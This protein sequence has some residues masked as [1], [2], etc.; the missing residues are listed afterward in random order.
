MASAASA[1][2]VGD[3]DSDGS[4]T[5]RRSDAPSEAS[6]VLVLKRLDGPDP[7]GELRPATASGFSRLIL[8]FDGVFGAAVLLDTRA[9]G[10]LF[11]L[12]ADVLPEGDFA[13]AA[14]EHC[15][16][17]FGPSL[18]C[19]VQLANASGSALNGSVQCLVVELAVGG[20]LRVCPYTATTPST[21]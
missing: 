21:T 14:D 18:T 11:V 3:H 19:T 5:G 6:T 2:G 7:L 16:G 12:P 13:T 15:A 20:D 1:A 10:G 17:F 4:A 8:E 9:G